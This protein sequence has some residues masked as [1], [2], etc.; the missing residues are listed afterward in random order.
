ML[1]VLEG[2][3]HLPLNVV[4]HP[5]QISLPALPNNFFCNG[6]LEVESSVAVLKVF[7]LE[8]LTSS[9]GGRPFRRITAIWEDDSFWESTVS[10]RHTKDYQNIFV[11][12]HFKVGHVHCPEVAQ[13]WVTILLFTILCL[14]LVD[15]QCDPGDNS[16]QYS[17][18]FV[19]K[20]VIIILIH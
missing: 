11:L 9:V 16:Q 2:T 10:W 6:F 1:S 12:L 8:T 4:C 14:L 7:P 5:T 20:T 13:S 3:D 17:F 15:D 18:V 19:L